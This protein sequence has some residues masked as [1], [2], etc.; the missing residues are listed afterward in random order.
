M[1][2]PNF[3]WPPII[4]TSKFKEAWDRSFKKVMGDMTSAYPVFAVNTE[5]N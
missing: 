3:E 2:Y 4:M 1:R 5:G